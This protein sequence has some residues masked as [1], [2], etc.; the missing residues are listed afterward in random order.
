MALM[1]SI[2]PSQRWGIARHPPTGWVLYFKSGWGSGTGR[3]DNQV[4]LLERG[5]EQ[6]AV[7]ILTTSQGDHAYGRRTLEGV[8][9]RLL[10]ELPA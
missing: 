3:V 2:V 9:R 4:A 7:A 6:V 5:D 10:R 8:A 1:R